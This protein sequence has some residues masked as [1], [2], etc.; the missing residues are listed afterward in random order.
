MFPLQY[1]YWF[2][3]LKTLFSYFLKALF[4]H[5]DI[6]KQYVPTYVFLLSVNIWKASQFILHSM[7]S[8]TWTLLFYNLDDKWSLKEQSCIL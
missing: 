1:S 7:D 3:C 2:T 8:E 4:L 6:W 5:S